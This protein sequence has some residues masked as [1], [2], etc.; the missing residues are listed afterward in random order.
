MIEFLCEIVE[1]PFWL[2]LIMLFC[3]IYFILF[4]ELIIGFG[5][6]RK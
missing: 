5:I 6:G 3:T 1:I 2:F 4:L